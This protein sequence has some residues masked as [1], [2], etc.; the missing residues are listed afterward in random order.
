MIGYLVR[1]GNW[2]VRRLL[3]RLDLTGLVIECVD[4]DRVAARI[5]VNAVA[6]RIDLDALLAAADLPGI[7][8]ESTGTLASDA[9]HRAR[10]RGMAADE[11]VDRI[12]DRLRGLDVARR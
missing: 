8:R 11:V 1:Q 6:R 7:I 5:D 2:A 12:R 3:G 10:M 4:L 9:V